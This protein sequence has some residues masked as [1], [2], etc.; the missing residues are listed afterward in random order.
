MIYRCRKDRFTAEEYDQRSGTFWK[1]P[2]ALSRADQTSQLAEYWRVGGKG[3]ISLLPLFGLTANATFADCLNLSKEKAARLAGL[4]Q[5]TV[6]RSGP[7]LAELKLANERP[8]Y[9]HGKKSTQWSLGSA[10]P[11]ALTGCDGYFYFSARTVYGGAWSQ[12]TGV[13]RALYLALGT[14]AK[15]FHDSDTLG[16][17]LRYLVRPD[18]P[19]TDIKNAYHHNQSLGAGGVRLSVASYSELAQMTGISKS[20]VKAAVAALKHPDVWPGAPT[21]DTLRFSPLGVLPSDGGSLIYLFRDHAEPWPWD[22]LNARPVPVA[23]AGYD[24]ALDD[25]IDLVD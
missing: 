3:V 22:V 13:Q 8:V 18:T 19:L 6:A 9:Y 7:V 21:A 5:S 16:S 4:S 24:D 25:L 17:F 12:L 10:F 23:A 20:G 15:T 11:I 14:R 2:P 1:M